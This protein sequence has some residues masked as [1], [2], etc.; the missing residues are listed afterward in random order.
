MIKY[1]KNFT[2]VIADTPFTVH[3]IEAMLQELSTGGDPP[4]WLIEEIT[5][6]R[7]NDR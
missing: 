5:K 2:D 3:D 1:S 4:E 7:R 6:C